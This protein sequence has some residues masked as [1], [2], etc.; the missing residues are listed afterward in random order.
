[1]SSYKKRSGFPN[2]VTKLRLISERG[3]NCQ[4]CGVVPDPDRLELDHIIELWEGGTNEDTNLQL[5]C[6]DCHTKKS[7]MGAKRYHKAFPQIVIEDGIVQ[8]KKRI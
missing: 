6:Y 8:P 3:I 7:S 1:M 4:N 5:L 2:Y